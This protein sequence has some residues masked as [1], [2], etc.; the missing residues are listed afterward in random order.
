[1][2]GG[3]IWNGETIIAPLP[4]VPGASAGSSASAGGAADAT[5]LVSVAD[6]LGASLDSS[7]FI[8]RRLCHSS[9]RDAHRAPRSAREAYES[10]LRPLI[11]G[12][13][14]GLKE[15]HEI[16]QKGYSHGGSSESGPRHARHARQMEAEIRNLRSD[17]SIVQWGSSIFVRANQGD[18]ASNRAYLLFGGEAAASS[19]LRLPMI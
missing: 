2:S 8:R 19:T 3:V 13:V 16:A 15:D 1:L 12:E 11:F 17:Q 5:Q 14:K 6:V 10:A 4:G 7:V 18:S 9:V